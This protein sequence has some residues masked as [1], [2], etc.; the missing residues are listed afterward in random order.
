[1]NCNTAAE[2]RRA[3]IRVAQI[4]HSNTL[5]C[6]LIRAAT[7]K[8]SANQRTTLIGI[9]V[10]MLPSRTSASAK[11][12][13]DDSM[14]IGSLPAAL[15]RRMRSSAVRVV[16]PTRGKTHFSVANSAHSTLRRRTNGWRC[17]A[18]TPTESR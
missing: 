14:I 11:C 1:V 12:N 8:S 15:K 10:S 3:F 4:G 9:A 17:A 13:D 7:C 2:T 5:P 6:T 18:N 16:A